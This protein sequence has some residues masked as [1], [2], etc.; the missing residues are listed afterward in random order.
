MSSWNVVGFFLKLSFIEILGCAITKSCTEYTLT[1]QNTMKTADS[2]CRAVWCLCDLQLVTSFRTC[3][4]HDLPQRV[5]LSLSHQGFSFFFFF[6]IYNA[7]KQMFLLA[8][9]PKLLQYAA[10]WVWIMISFIKFLTFHACL[11]HN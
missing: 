10:V 4:I 5:K 9:R 1:S 8:S 7:L 6:Q 3:S 11:A 2:W